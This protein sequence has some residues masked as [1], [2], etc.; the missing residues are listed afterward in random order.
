MFLREIQCLQGV[1]LDTDPG[2][3]HHCD[4]NIWV[5]W[6]GGERPVGP[7]DRVVVCLRSGRVNSR[8]NADWYRWELEYTDY[9]I[10]AWAYYDLRGYT[11][12][13]NPCA[14]IL[15]A[16][17]E[18]IEWDGHTTKPPVPGD[19]MVEVK[20]RGSGTPVTDKACVWYWHW[21]QGSTSYGD[22]VAYRF[23]RRERT[24]EEE[25]CYAFL[26]KAFTSMEASDE[27]VQEAANLIS[28]LET[29]TTKAA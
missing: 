1:R 23:T 21:P 22:I 14:E 17:T 26:K 11:E 20:F 19:T 12:E 27:W 29:H 4:L 25:A 8:P 18:W 2:L 9:D 16:R 28:M 7:R 5:P 13:V 15:E 10:V 6:H 24:A 3:E